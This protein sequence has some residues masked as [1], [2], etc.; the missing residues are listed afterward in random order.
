MSLLDHAHPV[1]G[2]KPVLVSG[3]ESW[4]RDAL[5]R[6][7]AGRAEE[8]RRTVRPGGVHATTLLPD[9]AGVIEALATWEAGGILAPL[10]PRLTEAEKSAAMLAL[11]HAARQRGIPDGTSAILW[12]SGTTGRPRGVA[13]GEH[14]FLDVTTSARERLGLSESDVWF[15]SLS[16]AHIGGLALVV[17]AVLLG[18]TLLAAGRYDTAGLVGALRGEAAAPPVTHVS[19]VPTQLLR[20]LEAWGGDPP[21]VPLRCV[22]LGGAETP[23]ELLRRALDAGW[24]IALTYGM[25]EMTSQVATAPPAAVRAKPGSV[26]APLAGVEL[27]IAD[28]GEIQVRGTTRAL[29]FVGAG[30]PL[31]DADGWYATGDLG[32]LDEEGDLWILGRRSDRILSGGVTVDPHEIQAALCE[33]PAVREACVVGVPDPEW[34]ERVAALVVPSGAGVD[35]SRIE[36]WARDRL[37]S[38]RLPRAWRVASHLPLNLNGKVDREAVRALFGDG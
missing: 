8:L 5:V 29:G 38:A 34:G 12:T 35:P 25:T 26:G 32:R 10:S 30:Q 27:R 16:L 28:D 9:P 6:A 31:A 4:T 22:L 3:Q 13:V 20:L 1:P 21:P 37:G 23:G 7:V 24:P 17:R 11:G 36:E 15:A 33:H 18:S 14:G 2:D 19:L